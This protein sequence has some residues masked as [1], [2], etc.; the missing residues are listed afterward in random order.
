[1]PLHI[2]YRPKMKLHKLIL[3]REAAEHKKLFGFEQ[4]YLLWLKIMTW[5][6][7]KNVLLLFY[8]DVSLII[9]PCLLRKMK[10]VFS[11]DFSYLYFP[12]TDFEALYKCSY[13][14]TFWNKFYFL[15]PFF[16]D[17]Q[18]GKIILAELLFS[19]SSQFLE[20]D[21]ILLYHRLIRWP[22]HFFRGY[23][24]LPRNHLYNVSTFC[25]YVLL[26]HLKLTKLKLLIF[27]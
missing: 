20:W 9:S 26:S 11:L 13:S 3:S 8:R 6:S 15:D 12:S 19:C 1:M 14:I 21:M 10:V 17:C 25:T 7:I 16:H 5:V 4:V 2:F 18:I 24:R 22:E 23:H 27:Q